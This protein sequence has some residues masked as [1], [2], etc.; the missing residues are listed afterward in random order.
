MLI[1]RINCSSSGPLYFL[2]AVKIC[3]QKHTEPCLKNIGLNRLD[4]SHIKLL[5]T[6]IIHFKLPQKIKSELQPETPQ[7]STKW[8]QTISGVVVTPQFKL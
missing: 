2:K 1:V 8:S 7:N 3:L 4:I 6:F 5:K